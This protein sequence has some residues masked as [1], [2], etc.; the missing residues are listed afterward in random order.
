LLILI[1]ETATT[2]ATFYVTKTYKCHLVLFLVLVVAV[3]VMRIS[4]SLNALTI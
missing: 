1:T 3:S 2:K 4:K